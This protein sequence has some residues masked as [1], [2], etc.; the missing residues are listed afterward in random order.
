MFFLNLPAHL[1]SSRSWEMES[2]GDQSP[3]YALRNDVLL[4]CIPTEPKPEWVATVEARYPGLRIRWVDRTWYADGNVFASESLNLPA[5]F[6]CGVTMVMSFLP[7]RPEDM[8]D[9]RFV[10]LTSA[11]ADRWLSHQKYH[12]PS[13]IFCTANGIHA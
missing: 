8:K 12:D 13:V 1:L 3:C 7:L 9:V 4:V 2:L 5:G 6:Y 11:G 10:Q